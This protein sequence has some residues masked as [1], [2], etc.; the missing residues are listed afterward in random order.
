MKIRNLAYTALVGAAAVALVI[1][2]AVPSEAAKKKQAA[3][4][5]PAPQ[6]VTCWV[7]PPGPVCATKGGMQFSYINSCYAM[8]DGA[9]AA[10]SGACKAAKAAK[11]GGKKKMAA[12][13]KT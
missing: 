3:A 11:V 2:S 8:K 1:G 7:T 5:P 4:A 10:K 6:P 13:K 9:T 12:A